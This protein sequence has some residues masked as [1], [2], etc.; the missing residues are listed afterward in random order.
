MKQKMEVENVA[1]ELDGI[2][3]FFWGTHTDGRI[4]FYTFGLML[5]RFQVLFQWLK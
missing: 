2:W 4:T 3:P 5:W 1:G